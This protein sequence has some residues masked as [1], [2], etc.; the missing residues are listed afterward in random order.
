M[1]KFCESSMEIMAIEKLQAIGYS[2]I[3]GSEITP[4][5]QNS[6]CKT[7]SDI[8]LANRLFSALSHLN[9]Y[10]PNEQINEVIKKLF[11]MNTSNLLSDNEQFHKLLIGG[12][13]IEYRKNGNIQSDFVHLIDFENIENNEFLVVNQYTIVENNNV[14][15]PDIILFINGIPLV[16]IE[17]K[18][19]ANENA[20]LFKVFEQIDTYKVSIPSLFIFNEICIISDGLE[21]KAGSFTSPFSRFSSWKIKNSI[22]EA[23][24][25]KDELTTLI[26]GMLSPKTLIDY[27]KNFITYEKIKTENNITQI[28][29]IETV[30]KIAA[31]HQYY[32]VNKAIY[33]TVVASETGGD[34]KAGVIW[35]TQGAG[36]SLS[37]AFY[38]GKIVQCLNNPTI[39]I[40]TDRNDLDDQIFDTFA[41]NSD[42]LK[43]PPKHAQSC[44]ELK[45][46]L[47]VSSGGVIFATIHKFIPEENS[48]VYEMLSKRDNIVVVHRT[49]YGFEAKL[50]NTKNNNVIGTYI[51]YGFAKYMQD[52]LPNATFIGFTGTPIKSKNTLEV[53]GSYIDIYDIAQA[54]A[55]K[56]TVKIYYES[57]ITKVNLSE[58]GKQLIEQFDKEL[59]ETDEI[60]EVVKTKTKWNKLEA[61]MG[62]KKRLNNLALD[63]V[64]HFESRQEV[65]KGKGII[66][67]MSRRI[68]V[69]LYEEIIKLRPNW[70]SQ[71]KDKGTIKVIMTASS[72]DIAKISKHHTTKTERKALSLRMKDENDS[73]KLVI[74][75]DIWFTGF[76]VPCLHT[77][78]IDKPMK[79]HNLMQAIARVNRVFYDKPGGLIV[80]YIGIETGLKNALS[81]YADSG[82]KGVLVEMQNRAVEMLLEKLEAVRQILYGFNYRA[83]FFDDTKDKLSVILQTEDYIFSVINGKTRFIKEVTLL[84]QAYALAKPHKSTI[85]NAQ[86]IAF[87]QEIKARLIKLAITSLNNNINHE[88]VIK[89]IV[90]SA[91]EPDKLID[92]F[93][94]TGLAKPPNSILSDDFLKEVQEMKY[95]NIAIELLK[96]LLFD[97]I[98]IRSKHNITKSKVLMEILDKS[99]K[100]Y[101]NNL[102]TTTE[103]I[104][105]LINIA[106]EINK[107]DKRSEKLGLKEDELAFY[108]ALE[109]TNSD[110]YVLDEIKLS[111]IACEI[112]EKVKN[113]ITIDWTIKESIRARL[114]VIV[115]RTLNKYGYPLDKQAQIIDI[116]MKQAENLADF[117]SK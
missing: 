71:D 51:I 38:T 25:F 68:A 43:Q 40:I 88:F 55:D 84:S 37:M 31:Y 61:I 50:R 80:D 102:F 1:P 60:E 73:L 78:Y 36:K 97:E 111:I 10:I 117:W 92:I 48:S 57:R 8:L 105:A 74:V 58:Q 103:I 42:L 39:L 87:F 79:E 9:P 15:R 59:E 116:I 28:I 108:D 107:S 113:N 110:T 20:T 29:K 44:K 5:P 47:K 33:N 67:T 98:K 77:I 89:N 17:L 18:N 100:Q 95:K 22:N 34:K 35:H 93:N 3:A 81:F 41:S 101:Q 16:I 56:I 90:N 63:I 86:E 30:K 14:K 70:H 46:M 85:E 82:G 45:Q 27:I 2:Y 109:L 53:F 106:K 32:A 62:N 64:D 13:Y 21:A 72:A 7:Y 4:N 24:N 115:K 54:V 96:K 26:S 19:P 11:Q 114:M 12:V 94:I 69:D 76:D 6:E 23:L 66:I 65:F 83:F 91:I 75:R 52:A 104:D 99:L 49:Q 112:V